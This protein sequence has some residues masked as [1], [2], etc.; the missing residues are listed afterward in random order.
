MTLARSAR[1]YLEKGVYKYEAPNKSLG[2][3]VTLFCLSNK[4]PRSDYLEEHEGHT[5]VI[6]EDDRDLVR[7]LRSSGQHVYSAVDTYSQER[8]HGRSQVG[9]APLLW[10]H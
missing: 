2:S 8:R 4:Y 9:N 3:G 6:K 10:W 5:R 1:V 7:A